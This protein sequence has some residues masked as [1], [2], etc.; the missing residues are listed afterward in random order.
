[1]A[2][3]CAVLDD[4]QNVALSLADWSKVKE[5][6]VKVFNE[7]LG[8]NPDDVIKALKG[9]DIIA[10]MRERT[11]FSRKVIEGLPDLKLLITT[12][13]AN[14][15]I[16]AAA[17]AERGI[18]V[19]GTSSYGNPTTGI[20]FGLMIELTRRIGWENNRMKTGH[21]WQVTL[22][23]DI[24]GQTIG[25]LGLG[26]LG[27]DTARKLTALGFPVKGWSRT[28]K[29]VAGVESFAGP[30][31]RAAFLRNHG[32]DQRRRRVPRT[33]HLPALRLA[34]HAD[35]L[36]GVGD[37]VGEHVTQTFDQRGL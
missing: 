8:H 20:T 14:R 27:Q 35:Q 15:S 16:D 18:T 7:H 1:M 10:M 36:L 37:I 4:F 3:R 11:P 2:H 22:G 34:Q 32:V 21:P 19:C 25:I 12:G 28:P 31:Q 24:E 26:T 13:A 23:A 29:T 30:E 5:V 6:E 17:C 9:F 33:Q